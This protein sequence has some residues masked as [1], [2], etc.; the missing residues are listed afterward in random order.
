MCLEDAAA[1]GTGLLSLS[2]HTGRP[3]SSFKRRANQPTAHGFTLIPDEY[4]P[5]MKNA[6]LERPVPERCGCYSA[7]T[8]PAA[9]L[10]DDGDV[11]DRWSSRYL[12]FHEER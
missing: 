11:D 1:Q 2:H 6:P 4:R 8:L 3:V 5:G 10:V 7:S 12:R 9:L